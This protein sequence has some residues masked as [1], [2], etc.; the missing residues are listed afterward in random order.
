M[1]EAPK[2]V[3]KKVA[4][5]VKKTVA[6]PGAKASV[7]KEQAPEQELK[8]VFTKFSPVYLTQWQGTSST[9]SIC[10]QDF[11]EYCPN[12]TVDKDSATSCPVQTGVCGHKY[13]MHC[14]D[15]WV[16]LG[17]PHCPLCPTVRWEVV[18]E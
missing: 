15:K 7:G 17:H 3:V 4:K 18:T 13:H 1:S 11:T 9:C 5:T 8:F 6:K 2:K 10:R 14:I 16:N 12:C